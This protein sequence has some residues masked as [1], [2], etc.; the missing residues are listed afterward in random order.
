MSD[1]II[2]VD[3]TQPGA[4]AEAALVYLSALIYPGSERQRARFTEAALAY[5]VRVCRRHGL[6]Q[7]T[8]APA[9]L[10][11]VPQREQRTR[12]QKAGRILQRRLQAARA[13]QLVI[14]SR[15]SLT[16][17][18]KRSGGNRSH[19]MHGAWAESLPV[20]HLAW[21]LCTAARPPADDPRPALLSLI[22]RADWVT[23]AARQAESKARFLT[24]AA[25][26]PGFRVQL[27]GYAA[28]RRLHVH[29]AYSPTA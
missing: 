9:A 13:L 14:A 12:L 5:G 24:A 18:A 25:Q 8:W 15:R 22:A 28:G 21:A 3:M 10:A 17:V 19:F 20:L 26:M 11:A 2:L 29:C 16:A 27:A 23:E 1:E 7:P 6:P 4:T